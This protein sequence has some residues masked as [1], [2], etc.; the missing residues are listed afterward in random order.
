P[1][2]HLAAVAR[3]DQ[4]PLGTYP[5]PGAHQRLPLAD[6]RRAPLATDHRDRD[7]GV[8]ERGGRD[9]HVRD[10]LSGGRDRDPHATLMR[11]PCDPADETAEARENPRFFGPHGWGTD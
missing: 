2:A 9:H 8:P 10:R 4:T 7:D 5:A 6:G 3:T 11:M 1:A